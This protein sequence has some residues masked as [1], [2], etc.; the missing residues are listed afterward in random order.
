M[1]GARSG[2]GRRPVKT[3]GVCRYFFAYGTLRRGARKDLLDFVG[4]QAK[5]LGRATAPGRLYD[6][7]DYPGMLD[8]VSGED[9][10]LGDL[11][12]LDD[13][14]SSLE[15]IDEYE[16]CEPN[17]R[18]AFRRCRRTVRLEGL[19]QVEACTYLYQGSVSERQRIESGD[20]FTR[21]E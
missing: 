6:L 12:E 20:Y 10:V 14:E 8:P 17:D 4:S 13:A 15:R 18:G 9:R 19:G 1:N 3:G 11:Y 21:R 16:G 7:G 5:L 2:V